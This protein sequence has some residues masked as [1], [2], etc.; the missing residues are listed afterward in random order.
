MTSIECF[1]LR[2][3]A[4]AQETLRRFTFSKDYKECPVTGYHNCSV[5][6]GTQPFELSDLEGDV[7]K[8]IEHDDS[9][10]PTKCACGYT[11]NPNDE[12]QHRLIRL[13]WR[14]DHLAMTCTLQDA[15]PGAMYYAN[16]YDWKGP[17]G[18]CLVVVTPAGPWIVDGPSTNN[19]GSKGGTWTRTGEL[20]K[21]TATPSINIP[22]KYHGWLKNGVLIDA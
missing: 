4:F 13:Y 9:R 1:L 8:G 15:P 21:V 14:S 11:F 16:W 12:W 17:D 5:E 3:S 19:D 7:G 18:K 2:P 22:G 10:W 6:I 20:P